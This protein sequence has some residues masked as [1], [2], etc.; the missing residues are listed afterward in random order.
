MERTTSALMG[1]MP[2]RSSRPTWV[3]PG[4]MSVCGERPATEEG[5]QHDRPQ[6]ADDEEDGERGAEPVR[7]VHGGEDRRAR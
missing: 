1:S 7:Q 2:T 4:R 6:H 3:S 5:R